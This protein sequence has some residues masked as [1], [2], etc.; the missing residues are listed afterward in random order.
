MSEQ[1]FIDINGGPLAYSTVG[2]GPPLVLLHGHLGDSRMW[3]EQIDILS[4]KYQVIRYDA[5]GYG[6]SRITGNSVVH[7]DDLLALLDALGIDQAA[8]AGI[9][10]G[11]AIALDVAANHPERVAALVLIGSGL[12][13]FVPAPEGENPVI[14]ELRAADE[15]GDK[16]GVAEGLLKLWTDG[17]R[18]P[19]QVNPRARAHLKMMTEHMIDLP[20]FEE[21]EP[22][23]ATISRLASIAVPTL[24][25]VGVLDRAGIREA[26]NLMAQ[27]MPRAQLALIDDAGHH[28]NVEHPD[29]VNILMLNF[30]AATYPAHVADTQV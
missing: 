30:L 11:G 14:D 9:S 8:L 10:G 2:N 29:E 4:D 27:E 7:H 23:P 16:A 1:Q 19:E 28:P 21:V 3:D 18:T 6:Q 13:G 5:R 26:A 17:G 15:R 20:R 22:I 25:V 24:I 12:S